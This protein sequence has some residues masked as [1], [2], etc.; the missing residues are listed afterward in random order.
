MATDVAPRA[1]AADAVTTPRAVHRRRGLLL[2]AAAAFNLWLWATRMRNL[3]ADAGDFST[4]FVGVH[5]VL[6]VTATAVAL[7]VGVI[8][9][10]QW[11]EAR[12]PAG[13]SA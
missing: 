7:V 2:L 3:L 8:G 13:T 11:R 9:F 5:A 1:G 6:Y 4:A 10:R 12:R